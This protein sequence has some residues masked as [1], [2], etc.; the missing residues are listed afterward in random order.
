MKVYAL[1]DS[2]S[3]TLHPW[4]ES[5]NFGAETIY[6]LTSGKIDNHFKVFQ[7]QKMLV[8][9]GL[10]V[11]CF[12]EIDIRCHVHKQIHVKGRNEDEV[13]TSLVDGY[14]KKINVLHNDIAVMSV[15]PPCYYDNRKSE[16]D[17]DP[18]SL[19][20]QIVGSDEDRSRYTRKLND[21]ME[22]QCVLMGIPYLDIYGLY[23]DE[24]GMLPV[25]VSDGNVHILNRG[26]VGEFLKAIDLIS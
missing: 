19:I 15:V 10:W 12:G 17:A 18:A 6:S 20:Y 16:V 22:E 8:K 21:Y 26:K 1:G 24:R 5:I 9:D 7:D 3:G 14:L 2:H 23:K 13:L 25:D 11:F 4:C